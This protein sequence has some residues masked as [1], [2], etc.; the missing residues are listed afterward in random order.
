MKTIKTNEAYASLA[1]RR[2]II[3]GVMTYLR[4]QF[5]GLDGEP[6]EKM[7]CEEVFQVDSMVPPEEVGYYIEELEEVEASLKL[8]MSKFEFTRRGKDE[9]Q[10]QQQKAGTKPEV[11]KKII[12]GRPVTPK[13]PS[14]GGPSN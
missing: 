14:T 4:R 13:I 6:K 5:L 9:Q 3:H 12:K 7:T 11:K 10:Q 2:T 1:Y 8:E